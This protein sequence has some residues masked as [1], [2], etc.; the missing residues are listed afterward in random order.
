MPIIVRAPDDSDVDKLKRAGAT[1]VIPEVLEGSLM[2]AAE[3]LTQLG[4][5]V[6][7]AIERVRLVREARYASMREFYRSS[8]ERKS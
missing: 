2:I 5:P 3:T 6:E 4:V 8:R 1:E 7:R